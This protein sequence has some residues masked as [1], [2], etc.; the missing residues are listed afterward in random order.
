MKLFTI[1]LFLFGSMIFA[2]VVYY[3]GTF[4]ILHALLALG[5]K[6]FAIVCAL[7]VPVIAL[8]GS[9]WWSV[10]RD[11]SGARLWKFVWARY[12]RESAA[13][14]LPF[15]QVGGII[16][17]ARALALTGMRMLPVAVSMLA[18]LVIEL[19]AKLPYVATG[20]LLLFATAPQSSVVKP[21][22]V[23]VL[24]VVVTVVLLAIFHRQIKIWLEE[25][26]YRMA[27][28]WPILGLGGK[29]EIRPI[30]DQV[31]ARDMRIVTALTIHLV[32]WVLGALE[33]LVI[34]H[35]MGVGVGVPEAIVIDSLVAALRTVGFAVPAAVGL[36]EGGY[37]LVC[38]LFGIDPAAAVALSLVRRAREFAM[39][40]PGLGLWQIVEGRR[41]LTW[42]RRNQSSTDDTARR[43]VCHPLPA[44]TEC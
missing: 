43:V 35:L 17:G 39:G 4:G 37:V 25:V 3:A 27:R 33:T 10:G 11:I 42:R 8:L 15:S 7:H 18:D 34:L 44:S 40:L 28:R 24:I 38:G 26:A 20:I 2:G 19:A 14:I 16:I 23:G 12:V 5:W 22:A 32:S 13:E 21:A 29:A 6:G 41:V 30:F 36:Q 31:F 1:A 9:A